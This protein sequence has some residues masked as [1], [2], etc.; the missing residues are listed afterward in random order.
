MYGP[1][2]RAWTVRRRDRWRQ[3][4][5]KLDD[6]RVFQWQLPV[7]LSLLPRP[8]R[9]SWVGLAIG[10]ALCVS[11]AHAQPANGGAATILRPEPPA[12][13]VR[14]ETGNATVR[15]SRLT[16]DFALDGVLNESIYTTVPPYTDFV[17]Q[18]P[19]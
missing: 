19:F 5:T 2:S 1:N 13:I 3:I 4:V 6:C 14:D 10:V 7:I 9:I 11:P 15:A 12:V 8:S 17:Q 16:G 18:E